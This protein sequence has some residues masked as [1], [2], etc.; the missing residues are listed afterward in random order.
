MNRLP[1]GLHLNHHIKQPLEL[2]SVQIPNGR[3]MSVS[4]GNPGSGRS[5]LSLRP[6][7]TLALLIPLSNPR[8]ASRYQPFTYDRRW[9]SA[10]LRVFVFNGCSG[11]STDARDRLVPATQTLFI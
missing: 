1:K 7:L 10:I 3:L 9:P 4:V 8:L 6:S 2:A 11:H 5:H